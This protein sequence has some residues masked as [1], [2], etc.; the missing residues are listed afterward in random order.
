[1]DPLRG[2]RGHTLELRGY[3]KVKRRYRK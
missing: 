1:M 2:R 3:I